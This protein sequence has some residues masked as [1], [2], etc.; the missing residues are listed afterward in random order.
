MEV[1]QFS[2]DP[3]L[4]APDSY[5]WRT[6]GAVAAV[7]NQ[8][9]CGS[10]WA[11]AAT[12]AMESA[13]YIDNGALMTFSEQQLVDCVTDTQGCCNGCNGGFYHPAWA[14]LAINSQGAIADSQYAYKGSQGT[15]QR[16]YAP[17]K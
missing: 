4:T 5:D 3:T 16:K 15:C 10:C 2:V 13:Y 8:G 17:S 9:Y 7:K 14:Y 6:Q 12:A 11:F 1:K